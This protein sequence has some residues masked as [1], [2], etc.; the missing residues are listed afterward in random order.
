MLTFDVS[1]TEKDIK[2]FALF[3]L[4]LKSKKILAPLIAFAAVFIIAVIIML[5]NGISLFG[6]LIIVCL[7]IILLLSFG[8]I[9]S[10][11]QALVANGLDL[12][13]KNRTFCL[14]KRSLRIICE[15]NPAYSN[16]FSLYDLT[17]FH[18]TNYAVYLYFSKT[19]YVIIPLNQLSEKDRKSVVEILNNL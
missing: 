5:F 16:Q 14:D 15:N 17:E 2:R 18:K 12:L 6:A 8:R 9:Y 1:L 13:N 7:V 3:K 11:Y 19:N 4:N 10:A